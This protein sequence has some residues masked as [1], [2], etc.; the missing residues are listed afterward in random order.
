MEKR[1]HYRIFYILTTIN[2]FIQEKKCYKRKSNYYYKVNKIEK[3]KESKEINDF[4][5]KYAD[6]QCWSDYKFNRNEKFKQYKKYS[7]T[8]VICE[9]LSMVWELLNKINSDDSINDD[10]KWL[11]THRYVSIVSYTSAVLLRDYVRELEQKDRELCKQTPK[12]T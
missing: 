3:S 5:F 2:V 11:A 1:L 8:N 9:E 10:D 6:L 7:D 4:H 12:P